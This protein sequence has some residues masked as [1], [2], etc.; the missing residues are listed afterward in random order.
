MFW[1]LVDLAFQK[2]FKN[3]P[4]SDDE[5]QNWSVRLSEYIRHH[6]SDLLERAEKLL[7]CYQD[8]YSPIDTLEEFMDVAGF[9]EEVG[10]DVQKFM[11][12]LFETLC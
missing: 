10:A 4:E 6:D 1:A 2:L 11:A 3:V 9:L 5:A 7:T 8:E 12:E